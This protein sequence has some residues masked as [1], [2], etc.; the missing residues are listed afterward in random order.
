MNIDHNDLVNICTCPPLWAG[1]R[2]AEKI[3]R[4]R[5]SQQSDSKKCIY[6]SDGEVWSTFFA[7]L[8]FCVIVGGLWIYPAV[9]AF[10]CP[11]PLW[12]VLILLF[13]PIVGLIF[14]IVG[15]PPPEQVIATMAVPTVSYV[16]VEA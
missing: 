16:P 8:F 12:G 5:N 6:G 15:C 13:G 4:A 7:L 3:N 1:Q 9:K 14:L 10:R 11:S 2:I